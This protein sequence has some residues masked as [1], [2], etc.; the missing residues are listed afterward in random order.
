MPN[1]YNIKTKR[2]QHERERER[3]SE[4]SKELAFEVYVREL[5]LRRFL[6]AFRLSLQCLLAALCK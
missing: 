4:R 2:K 3:Y 1:S 5:D 6:G